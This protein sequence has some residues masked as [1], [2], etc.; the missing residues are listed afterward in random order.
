MRCQLGLQP[1]EGLPGAGGNT[2]SWLTHV[3]F[4]KRTRFLAGCWQEGSV[5]SHV[6]LFPGVA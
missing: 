2:L 1:S 3:A 5:P 6:G 4:G